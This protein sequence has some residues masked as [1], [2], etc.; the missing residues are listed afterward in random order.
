MDE[1][2]IYSWIATAPAPYGGQAYRKELQ[3]QE[4]DWSK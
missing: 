4:L 3:P 1:E 2:I